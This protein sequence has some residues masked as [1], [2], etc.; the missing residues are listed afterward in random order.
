MFT[1]RGEMIGTDN[2]FQRPSGGLR[3]AL[4]HLVEG[5]LYPLHNDLPS[6][7][8]QPITG[9]L[10]PPISLYPAVALS[11]LTLYRGQ[12]FPPEMRDNLFSAQHNA[13]KVGRH[14]ILPLGATFR[15]EEADFVGSDDPDF[16]PS[17]VLEDADGSLLI[18]DT[19]GWYVQHCPTGKIRPSQAPG[20]IYRVRFKAAP[21]VPDPWGLQLNW[22]NVAA[23]QVTPR[24]EDT[25]PAVRDRAQRWLASRLEAA[26]DSMGAFLAGSTNVMAR[27]H[28]LWALSASA[29]PAALP[30]LRAA[31]A[32][33]E[34]EM[35]IAAARALALRADV[36]AAPELCRLLSN[37]S[38]AVR[39]AAAQALAH[40]GDARSLPALWKAL[41]KDDLDR[42]LEHALIHAMHRIA[43]KAALESALQ[44]R[45]PRVQK[46]ALVLLDQPPRS[47]LAHQEVLARVSAADAGLRQTALHILQQH[48]EWAGQAL[49]FMQSQIQKPSLLEEEKAG[50]RS[51]MLA[52]QAQ[53]TVQQLIGEALSDRPRDISLERCGFLLEVMAESSLRLIPDPWISGLA[54]S[55]ADV[56]LPVRTQ[57]ARTSGVLQIAALDDQLMRLADDQRASPE[58][59]LE[60][61]RAVVTR[62]PKVSPASF[63]LLLAQVSAS[64]SPLHRLTAA[65][66]LGRVQMSAAEINP[67]L[68]AVREDA[69]VSPRL[70]LPA[71]LKFNGEAFVPIFDY[72]AAAIHRGWR[73]S[74]QELQDIVSRLPDAMQDRGRSLIQFVNESR[75]G[76]GSRLAM[77]E[78]L[79][80][81]GNEERGR[82]VFFGT[83]APCATC[84]RIGAQGG[85]T[86][87]DLTKIGAV[88]SGRDLIESIVFPSSTFAQGYETHSVVLNEG[89]DTDGIIVRQSAETLVLRDSAGA[90]KLFRKD[91]IKELK[92]KAVSIMPEGLENALS[93]DEF[94]DLLAFLLSLK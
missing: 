8:P 80:S 50:L 57:A 3:D 13:R 1:L 22:T 16:H 29:N 78:P 87:P 58:L 79:L 84:H 56:D 53:T 30:L 59:R 61:L 7:T 67:L 90:E 42:F 9:E 74:E 37:E 60:S 21:R 14:V 73:P 66:I 94:R 36:K 47:S 20:G 17:D 63:A 12:A 55:L 49:A 41:A 71:L 76:E 31:L 86:G 45:H 6:S 2:W 10:L 18:V 65:E 77:F 91:E 28:A 51:L 34:P 15:T 43:D 27:Q 82:A 52:F 24:I 70:L 81:G 5:G 25:R 89:D 69:V 88:R 46:A 68:A 64:A 32:D 72:L 4:V 39:L 83:K 35:A 11:G 92:R 48:P 62:H 40:C 75:A 23:K 85:L 54:H 44:E 26:S 93:A 19:G 33:A 38:A